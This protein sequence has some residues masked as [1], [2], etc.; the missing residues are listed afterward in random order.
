LN[1]FLLMSSMPCRRRCNTRPWTSILYL[2]TFILAMF[3]ASFFYLLLPLWLAVLCHPHLILFRWSFLLIFRPSLS[4][5]SKSTH[6]SSLGMRSIFA[7]KQLAAFLHWIRFVKAWRNEFEWPG[8][9]KRGMMIAT[10]APHKLLVHAS[11][12]PRYSLQQTQQRLQR[13]GASAPIKIG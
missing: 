11:Y 3:L 13:I 5:W 6:V 1:C 12:C 4:W 10:V 7:F 8:G 2:F 9:V